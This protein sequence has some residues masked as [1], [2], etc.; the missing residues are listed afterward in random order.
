PCRIV[1]GLGELIS[2]RLRFGKAPEISVTDLLER[3][4]VKLDPRD[5]FRSVVGRSVLVTGAAGSIGTELCHQLAELEPRCLVAVDRA[6]SGRFRLEADLRA[7][8]PG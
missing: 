7:E 1:P 2:G 3:D 6:E 5:V 8:S 4:P